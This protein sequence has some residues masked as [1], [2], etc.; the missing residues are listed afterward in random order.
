MDD[1]HVRNQIRNSYR[2]KT[3]TAVAAAALSPS[4]SPA[5]DMR[6]ISLLRDPD[7]GIRIGAIKSLTQIRG[8]KAI[9][10]ITHAV[11]DPSCDVRIAACQALGKLRAHPAKSVLY[12]TLSDSAPMVCCSA[13]EALGLMGDHMGLEHV[14]K[15]VMLKGPHQRDA[16]RCLNLLTG[17]MFR[18][19]E[20]GVQ[21]AIAWIKPKKRRFF[22]LK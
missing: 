4:R 19:N 14:K 2:R 17:K 20:L 8:T 18:L 21:R 22:T 5:D 15:L 3:L 7:P 11:N 16:L 12:D 6:L 9:N 1:I 13:A 10:A